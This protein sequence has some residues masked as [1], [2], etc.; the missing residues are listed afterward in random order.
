MARTAAP[1][2]FPLPAHSRVHVQRL[3][4]NPDGKAT[5]PERL[6]A[7]SH[8]SPL[9][10]ASHRTERSIGWPAFAVL[11]GLDSLLFRFRVARGRRSRCQCWLQPPAGLSFFSRRRRCNSRPR[12]DID[13]LAPSIPRRRNFCQALV[14]SLDISSIG[15]K[16]IGRRAVSSVRR[17][18]SPLPAGTIHMPTR[19]A[20]R[21]WWNCH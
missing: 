12:R 6:A 1:D 17:S 18:W 10:Q 9:R 2:R 21:G 4:Q 19:F 7:S 5:R 20:D 13:D 14:G 15:Q 8:H 11:E 3:W 16:A